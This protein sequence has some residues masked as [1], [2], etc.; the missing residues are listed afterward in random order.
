[1]ADKKEELKYK[2]LKSFKN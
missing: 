2:V 1:M